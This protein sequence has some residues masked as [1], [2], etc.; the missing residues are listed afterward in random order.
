[1]DSRY[2]WT[3]VFLAGILS[4]PVLAAEGD[5]EA[6]L[7][8]AQGHWD[9][10]EIAAAVAE[11]NQVL[12]QDPAN[13]TAHDAMAKLAS[14]FERTDKYLDVVEKLI[15]KNLAAEAFEAL[16][17]WDAQFASPDQQAKAFIL[18]GRIELASGQTTAALTSFAWQSQ[19][20]PVSPSPRCCMGFV[21]DS[22]RNVL[23]AVGGGN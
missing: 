12:Q 3:V 14:A 13:K 17:R 10:M 15:D 16:K 2:S 8:K 7:Q 6:R 22:A 23:V 21:Y 1:M 5:I 4:L 11:W 20:P 9:R 19:S 18:R